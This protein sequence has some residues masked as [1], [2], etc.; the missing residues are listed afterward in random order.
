[1][2]RLAPSFGTSSIL[3][4]ALFLV[5]AVPITA[6]DVGPTL[7]SQP[8]FVLSEKAI[9]AGVDGILKAR[10]TIDKQ[11]DVAKLV[12]YVGPVWP[13][14]KS[15]EPEVEAVVAA[16][17]E[18]LFKS[19]FSPAMK[20]GK[21]RDVQVDLDFPIG[22][23]YKLAVAAEDAKKAAAAGKLTMVKAGFLNGRSTNLRRPPYVGIRGVATVQV[24]IDGQ[25][26][27]SKASGASGNP[28][29]ARPSREAAC[30]STFS[31]TILEGKAVLVS[32]FI[33]YN[34]AP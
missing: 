15:T 3:F 24:L 14:G 26:N 33:T 4:P 1:M 16:V 20:K 27:V 7:V 11:G 19:K 25:G 2:P 34:Y 9:T 28:A 17:E 18:H 30:T 32:G 6:Q 12:V 22:E 10:L 21:P 5:C 29:L 31:P 23:A 13:C 8:E